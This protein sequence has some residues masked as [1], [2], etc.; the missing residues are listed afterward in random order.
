MPTT[1][2]WFTDTPEGHSDSYVERFRKMAQDG[3]DLVGEARLVDALVRPRSRILD[4]GC[5]SGRVGAELFRRGHDVVGV[6]A[7]Q[8]LLAAAAEDHAGPSWVR[9]D[10]AELDLS[11]VGEAEPFDAAVMAG[12]VMP[13][14]AAGTEQAV[15]QRLATH[16]VPGG[17][18]V[19]G[20]GLDR[21]YALTDFDRHWASA[22]LLLEL[23]L[24]T[25][26]VSPFTDQS[27]FAVTLLRN[28]RQPDEPVAAR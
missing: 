14:L 9:A 11:A 12:N 23:R 13:Y 28:G 10:L 7:D 15:L 17:R 24:A 8:V 25:W 26:D 27:S 20:F 22:G 19:V 16:L 3:A 2:R 6:D 4:A 21:G 18:L 5:G 1:P